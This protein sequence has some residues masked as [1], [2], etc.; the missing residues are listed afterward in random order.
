M[1]RGR[2]T[3]LTPDEEME[4]VRNSIRNQ[5]ALTEK[6]LPKAAGGN[7]TVIFEQEPLFHDLFKLNEM[8]LELIWNDERVEPY[9]FSEIQKF[10]L[11]TYSLNFPISMLEFAAM[12]EGLKHKFNPARDY[13]NGLEWDGVPRINEVLEDVLHV[14]ANELNVAYLSK[15][16]TATVK[17]VMEPGCKYDTMF[18]LVGRQGRKKGMFFE[19]LGGNWYGSP[20]SVKIADKDAKLGLH[21]SLI[22]EIQEVDKLNGRADARDLK[23]LMSTRVDILRPPF[24]RTTGSYPRMFSLVGSANEPEG[25]L[26]DHTGNRRWWII[27]VPPDKFIDVDLLLTIKDQ[28]WAEAVA[29]YRAGFPIWLEDEHLQDLQIEASVPYEAY[30]PFSELFVS[31]VERLE[32]VVVQTWNSKKKKGVTMQQVMD[33][34]TIPENLRV[35]SAT[36]IIRKLGPAMRKL[37]WNKEKKGAAGQQEI[38]WFPE[39]F[40]DLIAASAKK[41]GWH[42][43]PPGAAPIIPFAPS[44]TP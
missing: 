19:A 2:S 12:S 31:N 8:T 36:V 39:N 26:V 43:M 10:L 33:A 4:R 34:I 5:L 3:P 23:T 16:L 7:L 25:I 15:F 17:R 37:G 18:V 44:V 41:G 27:E 13:Y 21:H 42:P 9:H 22:N 38:R 30:D 28:L 24:G 32:D 14:E 29:M 40:E 35:S 20:D 6:G 1:S 11:F